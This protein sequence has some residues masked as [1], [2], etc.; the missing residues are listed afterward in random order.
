MNDK[1]ILLVG[2]LFYA[3]AN[4]ATYELVDKVVPVMDSNG[5]TFMGVLFHAIVFCIVLTLLT[6]FKM[7][8][9]FFA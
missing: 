1:V 2:A 3:V 9:K 6:K 5:P 8:K 7:T 4:P